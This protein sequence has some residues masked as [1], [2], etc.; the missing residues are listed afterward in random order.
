MSCRHQSPVDGLDTATKMPHDRGAVRAVLDTVSL[1]G[2]FP[3]RPH[4]YGLFVNS[5]DD[6]GRYIIDWILGLDG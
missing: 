4:Q 2:T 5:G 6:A 1:T 3:Y